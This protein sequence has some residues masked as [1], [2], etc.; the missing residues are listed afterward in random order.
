LFGPRN[1]VP[2]LCLGTKQKEEKKRKNVQI[3]PRKYN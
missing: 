1:D 2:Q 3:T